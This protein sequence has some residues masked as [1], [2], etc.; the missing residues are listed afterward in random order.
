MLEGSS[1]F[2]LTRSQVRQEWRIGYTR[3]VVGGVNDGK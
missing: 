2:D 1:R 3:V